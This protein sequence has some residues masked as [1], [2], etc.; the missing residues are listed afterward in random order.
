MNQI[1]SKSVISK[2]L[3]IGWLVMCN[4]FLSSCATVI[5]GSTQKIP[6][7]SNPSNALARIDGSLC[8]TTPTVFKLDRNTD[9][10][11]EI[12]KEGY[13]TTT[14]ILRKALSGATSG[15]FL[16]LGSAGVAVDALSGSEYKL[17]PEKVDVTLTKE[18]N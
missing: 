3:M 18:S 5:T 9:H 10:V 7:T 6:V 8:A 1:S 17:I 4:I 14:I 11:V 2:Y 13:K 12:S 15:N 16:G